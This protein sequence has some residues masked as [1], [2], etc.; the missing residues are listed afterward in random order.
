M[1]AIDRINRANFIIDVRFRCWASS[2]QSFRYS[3]S[4]VYV[5]STMYR[6]E[7][8]VVRFNDFMDTVES[9]IVEA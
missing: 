8:I 1:E 6:I 3:I 7:E 9:T 2:S 5:A 4:P